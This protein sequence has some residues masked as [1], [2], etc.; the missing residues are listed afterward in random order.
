[1]LRGHSR[2]VQIAANEFTNLGL[3]AVVAWG[4]V[5]LGC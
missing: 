4:R 3:S 1:M 5:G 2:G